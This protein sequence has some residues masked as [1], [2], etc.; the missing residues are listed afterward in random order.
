MQMPMAGGSLPGR[1]QAAMPCDADSENAPQKQ[2]FPERKKPCD[3]RPCPGAMLGW[4]GLSPATDLDIIFQVAF[5]TL[6]FHAGGRAAFPRETP[7]A[8]KAGAGRGRRGGATRSPA[9]T[10]TL[11]SP[12]AASR[13]VVMV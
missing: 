10:P 8:D 5:G 6:V 11:I 12:A 9:G 1:E 7:V 13:I 3:V 4:A 2:S